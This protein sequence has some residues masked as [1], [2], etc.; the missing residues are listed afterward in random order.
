MNTFTVEDE[1]EA[2]L[3]AEPSTRNSDPQ[4]FAEY[5]WKKGFPNVG[6]YEFFHYFAKYQKTYNIPTIETLRRARQKVQ[7][8]RNDI[9]PCEDVADARGEKQLE[10][11]RWA[12]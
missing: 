9:K 5:F 3:V 2:I 1:V 6:V 11:Y 8:R 4:L 12:K 10:F 7:A